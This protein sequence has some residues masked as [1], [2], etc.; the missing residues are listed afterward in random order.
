MGRNSL[1]LSRFDDTIIISVII[2]ART[3]T[4]I[5]SIFHVDNVIIYSSSAVAHRLRA[6]SSDSDESDQVSRN[7]RQM[8]GIGDRE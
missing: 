5:L 1:G 2:I 6:S 3:K 8:I 7:R 4:I